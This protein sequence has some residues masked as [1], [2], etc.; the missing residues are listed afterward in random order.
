MSVLEGALGPAAPKPFAAEQSAHAPRATGAEAKASEV[1]RLMRELSQEL[2]FF[3]RGSK[4]DR[5]VVRRMIPG[6]DVGY[7]TSLLRALYDEDQFEAWILFSEYSLSKKTD[8][9]TGDR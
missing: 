6:R 8:E 7:L 9:G 5:D 2:E 4:S 1:S 3:K